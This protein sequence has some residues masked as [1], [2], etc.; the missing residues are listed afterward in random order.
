MVAIRAEAATVRRN[1]V[2]P[3]KTPRS[4]TKTALL[5][6]VTAVLD[7]AIMPS[8]STDLR[9]GI[10][11]AVYNYDIEAFEIRWDIAK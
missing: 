11:T 8:G 2:L 1:I 6:G 7:A 4:A 3:P 9:Q 5:Q 10:L